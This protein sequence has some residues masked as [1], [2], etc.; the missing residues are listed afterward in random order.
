MSATAAFGMVKY[1][2]LIMIFIF[3]WY[4]RCR[5]DLHSTFVS[6]LSQLPS[7]SSSVWQSSTRSS[8]VHTTGYRRRQTWHNVAHTPRHN[9]PP[10]QLDTIPHSEFN[11]VWSSLVSSNQI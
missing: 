5:P 11:V 4:I 3:T 6:A 1:C 7:P 8:V 9:S 2:W 10:H